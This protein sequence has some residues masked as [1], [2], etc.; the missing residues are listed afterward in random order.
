MNTKI[1]YLPYFES[2]YHT[3]MIETFANV[4][5]RMLS[6]VHRTSYYGAKARFYLQPN[7]K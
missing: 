2:V 1:W 3:G 4:N 5:A 6:M 7:H